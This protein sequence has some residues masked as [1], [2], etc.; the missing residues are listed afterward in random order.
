[1]LDEWL[2]RRTPSSLKAKN[3]SNTAVDPARVAEFEQAL[4]N[5]NSD[6]RNLILASKA[7]SYRKPKRFFTAYRAVAVLA[8]SLLIGA[9][10]WGYMIQDYLAIQYLNQPSVAVNQNPATNPPATTISPASDLANGIHPDPRPEN[11]SSVVSKQNR[12]ALPLDS[13]PFNQ[14]PAAQTKSKQPK[15]S[16][17]VV[18]K[19]N[20]L[21]VVAV[22][23][24]QLKQLWKN[25]DLSPTPS[26]NSVAWIERVYRQI[27]MRAPTTD[28]KDVFVKKDSPDFR[29]ETLHRIADS[30][31]FTQ[32]WAKGLAAHYLG[33]GTITGR[34]LSD[35]RRAFVQWIRREL[36]QS[37]RL[38]L[39][40]KNIILAGGPAPQAEIAPSHHWWKEAS[41][42]GNTAPAE[43]IVSKFMGSRA[44]CSRCH[45]ASTVADANQERLW[46]I[47]S[48]ARGIDLSQ[49]SV[50]K[51]PMARFQSSTDPLFYERGDG[52]MV[53]ASPS[54]PN[55]KALAKP[56]G[57]P[58]EAMLVSK[59]NLSALSDWLV[60]SDELAMS[61]ANYVW[62][63]L[64]GQPL[65]P[66]FPIDE[67]QGRSERL[68]LA[69]TLGMQLHANDYDL[70]QIVVWIA[71]SDAFARSEAF[72]RESIRHDGNWYLTAS[73]KDLR[74]FRY[75]QK[76]F[77]AFSFPQETSF[78]TID[79]LAMWLDKSSPSL[80]G[81]SRTLANPLSVPPGNPA[82]PN[83]PK[84]TVKE[85]KHDLTDSQ[86]QYLVNTQT[87]PKILQDE[88]DRMLKANLAWPVLVEH[89]YYMTG[90]SPPNSSDR[91]AAQKILDH[92]RD[93]RLAITRIIAARL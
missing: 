12:E 76:L 29:L 77:A 34:D 67:V 1:M 56:Q 88:I 44:S 58:F 24:D 23:N 5:A 22:V 10:I 55:G 6:M 83:L 92:C 87:L 81:R 25:H 51:P 27:L 89:A 19:L 79:N 75:R 49:P 72:A 43:L 13:L 68:S 82:N 78:R 84:S 38:D 41:A 61:Q 63:T 46:G 9:G 7:S 37:H 15:N 71:A 69:K 60:T 80:G 14:R 62:K 52:T 47:A 65:L 2:G 30:L 64:L 18:T 21:E 73:E 11:S 74:A 42:R 17:N 28:E 16:S 31:E 3:L 86:V 20:E 4:R 54:L 26:A 32:V 57:R 50:A 39:V 33:T 45:D 48:I 90:I 53:A 36:N 8:A 66:D 35:E 91:E 59:K 85:K 93:K 70:R 40:A